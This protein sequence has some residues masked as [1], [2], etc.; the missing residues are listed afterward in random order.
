MVFKTTVQY[1][2][3]NTHSNTRSEQ[4]IM[5]WQ[6]IIPLFLTC[7]ASFT[8]ALSQQETAS[9]AG[10]TEEAAP[11][12]ACIAHGPSVVAPSYTPA[13]AVPN[14]TTNVTQV[15][16]EGGK[17]LCISVAVADIGPSPICSLD[18]CDCGGTVAPLLSSPV[19]VGGTWTTNCNY[20]IRPA[21]N[22]CPTL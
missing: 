7:R 2:L 10:S 1:K 8:L 13:T 22:A 19:S 16:G 12:S 5:L 6:L 3:T 11:P 9:T 21:T 17:P 20:K 14:I 4:Y 15:P 18:Y